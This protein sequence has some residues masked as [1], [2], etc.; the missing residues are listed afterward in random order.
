MAKIKVLGDAIQLSTTITGEEMKKVQRHAP[1]ALKLKDADGNETFAIGRGAAHYSE[2]GITFCN[3]DFEGKLYLTTN[4]PVTEHTDKAAEKERIIERFAPILSKL[5]EI[6]KA[7]ND[8]TAAVNAL[9]EEMTDNVV[10]TDE[11][12]STDEVVE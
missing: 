12:I 9:E 8:A 1:D 7:V 10:F 4:N 2:Y 11:E 6:E 5:R 3:E